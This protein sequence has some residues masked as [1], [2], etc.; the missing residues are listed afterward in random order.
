MSAHPA[1]RPAPA[2]LT[3]STAREIGLLLA[4]TLLFPFLIHLI[5]GSDDSRLGQRLL[6][7]FY[8]PLL[9]VLWGRT[10][11][12]AIVAVVAPWLN[13]LLT[14][15][16]SPPSATLMSL[17]LLTFTL[18][19]ATLRARLGL[20]WFIALPAYIIGRAATII[21]AAVVPSLINH[22]PL[23][24]W[25]TT[26]TVQALPGLAVLILLTLLVQ[27]FYPPSPA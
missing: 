11:S 15:H 4:L 16:P 10:R 24:D 12:A 20:R 3:L 22:R 2:F 1:P 19:V 13:W 17:E 18:A 6:P 21:L 5:P 25:A 9:G 23:L 7:M 26:S 14:Q 27:R 8:S